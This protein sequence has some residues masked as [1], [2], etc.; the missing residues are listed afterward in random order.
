MIE[1]LGRLLEIGAV[2]AKLGLISFGGGTATLA[3]MQ[4]EAV[5]RGW[6]TSQQFVQAY[7][8]G[9]ITPGPGVTF[10]VPMGYR[11]GG[12]LGGLV[13]IVAYFLPAAL[14]ALAVA[15][16]WSRI[17][18]SPWPTAV[19]TGMIPVAVGLTVASAYTMVLAGLADLP[20]IALALAAWAAMS[21]TPVP[22]PVVL[23]AGGV[24]GFA[25][26]QP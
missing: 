18:T 8:L 17:R 25:F 24:V 16:V 15:R 10:V 12:V 22:T 7:A 2:L 26:L 3:E 4:R 1:E 13:A 19:R 21:R 9:Q 6:M 20:S 5:E 23:I 14:V 11:A